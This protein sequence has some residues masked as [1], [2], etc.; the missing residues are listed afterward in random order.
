MFAVSLISWSPASWA[1][2]TTAPREEQPV[3]D[4]VEIVDL[5]S[6]RQFDSPYVPLVE[7]TVNLPLARTLPRGSLLVIIDHRAY[8][9]FFENSFHDVM[10]LEAGGIKIGLGL[11]YGVM[12]TLDLGF[13]RLN[14]TTEIF[15]TYDFD[16]RWRLLR[17]D[18]QGLDLALRG[19]PTWFSQPGV[20][21]ALGASAQL[22]VD[23]VMWERLLLGAG[24]MYHS[25]SSSDTK[26]TSDTS[27][28][29][30]VQG[31]LEWRITPNLAWDAEVAA[32]VLGYGAQWP[33]VATALKIITHRH[34]FSFIL[35]NNQYTASDG[36]VANTWRSP[37]ELSLGFQVLRQMGI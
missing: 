25:D 16:L 12:D 3:E 24:F 37:A 8:K 17:Q 36:V 19:G 33:Q 7:R 27:W 35:S 11:R 23:R 10:G 20:P 18:A 5:G 32:N 14:G 2:D 22:L 30:A 6:S 34:T 29:A 1:Q 28:S 26:S 4:V 9:P 13:Y 21:D 31:N 15:D